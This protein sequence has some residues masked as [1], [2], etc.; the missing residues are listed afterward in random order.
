MSQQH[1]SARCRACDRLSAPVY[2]GGWGRITHTDA[3]QCP[4]CQARIKADKARYGFGAFTERRPQATHEPVLLDGYTLLRT[5]CEE[6]ALDP[7]NPEHQHEALVEM[8][9]IIDDSPIP[10]SIIWDND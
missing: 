5:V 7:E 2:R 6:Y 1:S 3:E 8:S 9:S 4:R 10:V